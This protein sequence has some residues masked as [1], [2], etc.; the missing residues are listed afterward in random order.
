MDLGT[1][2]PE[3]AAG[4][5]TDQKWETNHGNERPFPF[6]GPYHCQRQLHGISSPAK[7]LKGRHG[8]GSRIGTF[9]KW[10]LA[11]AWQTKSSSSPA[12]GPLCDE[13]PLGRDQA[14]AC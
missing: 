4:F 8:N 7:G 6:A 13:K 12:G 5:L 2:D 10:G 3:M 14:I 9:S 1:L 11:P